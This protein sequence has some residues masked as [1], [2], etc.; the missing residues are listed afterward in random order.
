[1]PDA[2]I[3]NQRQSSHQRYS[4]TVS[5]VESKQQTNIWSSQSL[6]CNSDER[7]LIS[8]VRRKV[9]NRLVDWD[10]KAAA[11]LRCPPF[12]LQS[13]DYDIEILNG[14]CSY[15]TFFFFFFVIEICVKI[16]LLSQCVVN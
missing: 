1:M 10:M 12:L 16:E 9:W 6:V 4:E 8:K 13:F 7:E 3:S 11:A 2:P 14:S 5:P 15:T